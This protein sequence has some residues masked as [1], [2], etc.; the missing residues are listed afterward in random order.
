[1][2]TAPDLSDSELLVRTRQR[3]SDGRLPVFMPSLITAGY[4]TGKEI[5]QI[6]DLAILPEHAEYEVSDPRTSQTLALHFACYVVW[7]RECAKASA[8]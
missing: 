7:Q 1:M 8:P 5:C 4:G 3:I 6:C 2:P